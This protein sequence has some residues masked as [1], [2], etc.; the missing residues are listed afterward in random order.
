[1]ELLASTSRPETGSMEGERDL[2]QVAKDRQT[3]VL[4][5]EHGK[6]RGIRPVY[7][8]REIQKVGSRSGLVPAWQTM[9]RA[10]QS[11]EDVVLP[12]PSV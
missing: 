7:F 3:E 12:G 6:Q 5:A 2:F 1:M 10:H 9:R 4:A 8:C 11:L